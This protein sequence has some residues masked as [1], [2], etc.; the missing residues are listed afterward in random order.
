[1]SGA[2]TER[3]EAIKKTYG[4]SDEMTRYLHNLTLWY[5]RGIRAYHLKNKY[6]KQEAEEENIKEEKIESIEENEQDH[7][8]DRPYTHQDLAYYF[9]HLLT[10]L[11]ESKQSKI[12]HLLEMH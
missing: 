2:E 3:K 10:F 11:V 6:W 12:K 4:S 7:K 9:S 8:G 1:L 5:V